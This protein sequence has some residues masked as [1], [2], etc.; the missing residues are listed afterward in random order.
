MVRL[1]L[2]GFSTITGIGNRSDW[3]S[4]MFSS[5]LS[6]H[7]YPHAPAVRFNILPIDL[8]ARALL[9]IEKANI[10]N[11]NN[12]S[13][14]VYHLAHTH[15]ISLHDVVLQW[16]Q[17]MLSCHM[18]KVSSFSEWM[19]QVRNRSTDILL[20]LAPFLQSPPLPG[21]IFMCSTLKACALCG[22]HFEPLHAAQGQLYV[23]YLQST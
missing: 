20:P 11:N 3:F 1:G 4:L 12:R 7:T 23:R 14:S 6:S 2:L 13:I 9:A 5:M 19:Q 15:E 16:V 17:P 21:R 22:V 10:S 8:A 18:S